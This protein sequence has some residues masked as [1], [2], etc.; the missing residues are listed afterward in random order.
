MLV[1]REE[2]FGPIMP[3][4]A[5]DQTDELIEMVNDSEYAL[6]AAAF[7]G[8][9]EEALQVARRINAGAVSINEAA[10]NAILHASDS[11]SFNWEGVGG[12]RIGW[13]NN[14][15]TDVICSAIR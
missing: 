12:L 7:A 13:S 11:V 1:M 9:D 8:S 4:M 2:T 14:I 10:L 15:L 3:V 6:G 5:F